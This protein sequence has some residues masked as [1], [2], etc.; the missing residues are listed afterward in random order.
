MADDRLLA[1]TYD[2]DATVAAARRCHHQVRSIDGVISIA[3]DAPTTV[4]GVAVEFALPGVFLR[5]S[6][7][8]LSAGGL[9]LRGP[10]RPCLRDRGCPTTE[11]R[12]PPHARDPTEHRGGFR[13]GGDPDRTR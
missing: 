4:A 8:D 6:T 7:V 2:I 11:R 1:S 9:A 5:D 12:L 13:R 10:M 3:S